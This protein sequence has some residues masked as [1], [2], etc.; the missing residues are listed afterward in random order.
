M[1]SQYLLQI[2]DRTL[3]T[4]TTQIDEYNLLKPSHVSFLSSLALCLVFTV[5]G[6]RAAICLGHP[7][8]AAN[9]KL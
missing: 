7:R 8:M 6:L 4:P 9:F 5:Q 3:S 1:W 2:A